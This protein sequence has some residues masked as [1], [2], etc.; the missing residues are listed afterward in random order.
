MLLQQ[1]FDRFAEK[2]PVSMISRVL[3]EHALNPAD[4]DQLFNKNAKRQYERSLLFSTIVDL[5]GLVVT[6]IEPSIH[7]AY[8]AVEDTL[9]VSLTSLY[10]KLNNTE[11]GLVAALVA[12]TAERLG[13]VIG[14]LNGQ[15]EPLLPGYRVRIID[16]NH[17]AATERRLEVLR[18]CKAGP[19]PGHALVVLDP[20]LMLA[21]NMIPCEDGH[22]QERALSSQIIELVEEKDVWIADRNFC[23]ATILRGIA[24]RQGCFVIR[25]HAQLTLRPVSSLKP[26]GSTETGQ[27]FEQLVKLELGGEEPLT[28]RRIIVQLDTPTR[29]GDAQ[30]VIL[31]NL[32]E[33][34]AD[35]VRIVELYRERWTLETMFQSLTT[36][37]ASE[38]NTLGYPK[39]ALLGFGVALASYNIISTV[40][41]SLRAT[42]GSEK[43]EEE[44]S[45]YYI[46][47]EVRN[48]N[49]GMSVALPDP[50]WEPF[51]TMSAAE[52]AEK[53]LE[54]A[55][56]T[57]LKK[58]KRHPRGPKKPVP[59]R[60]RYAKKTHVS[61]A[62]LLWL[63]K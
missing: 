33:T 23:T 48:I 24:A 27:V 21:T 10:N 20:S 39:A 50:I 60:T 52:I 38:L 4:L 61:T 2:T 45:G 26:C 58:F 59:P 57:N 14:E 35:G 1:I 62:R 12:H 17:L 16:G 54:F 22:T 13:A 49:E 28:L 25:A 3:M 34:A 42:F 56:K 9:P 11:P 29:D 8:Q 7:A 15:L 19:L 31:S 46:A 44:V 37:F 51:Q 32:P 53:V 43:I 40:Q 63:K 6:K 55:A 41:A 18:G 36:L 5:M 30:I 47:N